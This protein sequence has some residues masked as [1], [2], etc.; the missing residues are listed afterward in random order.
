METKTNEAGSGFEEVKIKLP[1]P[2]DYVL[3]DLDSGRCPVYVRR[4]PPCR[5]SCPSSEDIRGYLTAIAQSE[6][7]K[8]KRSVEESLDL[9][10]HTLTD[11]NPF[12]AVH[13]RICPH[14]CE[15]GC[16][17]RYKDEAVAINNVERVIGDHGI[18]RGLKLK[19]LT[20][21]K[22]DRKA[23]VIGAGPSGLSC[24]YQLAR[25]GY[26]VTVFESEEKPGGMLR[27]GIPAYRLPEDVLDAEIRNI[28]ELGVEL[29]CG[30]RVGEDIPWD[31]VRKEYDAVYVAVGA[32]RGASLKIE[33]EDQEGVLAGV[34]FLRR[35]NNGE[36]VDVG[37]SVIVIGGGNTAV[38]AARVSRRLGA[39]VTILYRRTRAEMPA[40]R[41]EITAA[42]EED[43]TLE[44]L[45]APV[46]IS[47]AGGGL[48]VTCVRMEL[49]EPDESGRRR[50]VPVEGSEFTI[51]GDT[52]IAAIGQEPDLSQMEEIADEWGWA[53]VNARKETAAAGVFAGGDVTALDIA[54][55]A[56]GHGRQ[57]ARAMDAYF[58]EE[59]YREPY[60]AKPVGHDE[61]RLDYYGAAPRH[62]EDEM[63]AEERLRS[64]AEVNRA[65]TLEDAVEETKRCMS[66]GLCF[67]C[68]Q[69]RIYC[70]REAI[71]KD[72]G[73]PQ[74][75]TMFVDY[76]KC[77]GCGICEVACPCHYI[78]MGMGG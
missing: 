45:A 18:E 12:P 1:D 42:E 66:C 3:Q 72:L 38:D 57:A 52:V 54:T 5:T 77:S 60:V 41:H 50:P 65:L 44:L 37:S 4:V 32:Q 71:S 58:R 49:G 35:I 21:E 56:V 46:S 62:V 27:Y 53:R 40:I 10:W 7:Y 70:Q 51:D 64:F 19:M 33:G 30:V 2:E 75:S 34:D 78:E 63:P 74:G 9:A 17:R 55:T 14:P 29:R 39:E 11:K 73:R 25:R 69:C 67:S 24:A 15:D 48:S 61:M 26:P 36:T 20:D 43:V 6:T 13:G 8:E 23:A 76:A 59:E 28:I 68:D 16:N 31:D 47:R 22:R